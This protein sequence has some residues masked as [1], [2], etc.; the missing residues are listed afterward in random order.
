MRSLKIWT[1]AAA[2]L[3]VA[4]LP[5]AAQQY[6]ALSG[7]LLEQLRNVVTFRETAA[8]ANEGKDLLSAELSTLRTGQQRTSHLIANWGDGI[9][10]V[11][12]FCEAA[13]SDLD[14][15]VT[16][17]DTGA[18]IV[19]DVGTDSAPSVTFRPEASR[20]YNIVARMYNCTTPDGCYFVTASFFRIE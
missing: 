12:G 19:S 15:V 11:V 7:P 5:A 20:D 17:V 18:E 6:S 3:G 2:F 10:T 8:P 14:L 16:D 4:I 9:I 1:A 13:C